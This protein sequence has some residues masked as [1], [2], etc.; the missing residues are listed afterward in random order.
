M[1]VAW[2]SPPSLSASGDLRSLQPSA[3]VLS[4][5]VRYANAVGALEATKR[6]RFP[7]FRVPSGLVEALLVNGRVFLGFLREACLRS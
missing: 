4:D 2:F 1:F 5:W 6:A 3:A 7:L